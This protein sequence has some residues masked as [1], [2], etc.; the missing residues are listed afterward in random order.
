MPID[1][2]KLA[3]GTFIEYVGEF[4]NPTTDWPLTTSKLDN[5]FLQDFTNPDLFS[6]DVYGG[7]CPCG[8]LIQATRE[9]LR[10]RPQ[11]LDSNRP[12]STLELTVWVMV[13]VSGYGND[14]LEIN[15]SLWIPMETHLFNSFFLGGWGHRNLNRI[16]SHWH[17]FL[18][19][20][21]TRHGCEWRG[22]WA[23]RFLGQC[24]DGD[25]IDGDLLED[26]GSNWW[27]R[28]GSKPYAHIH[29]GVEATERG[30]ANWWVHQ[31]EFV[32]PTVSL[33]DVLCFGND[34]KILQSVNVSCSC[35]VCWTS[36]ALGMTKI[37]SDELCVDLKDNVGIFLQPSWICWRFL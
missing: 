27:T 16:H 35:K 9:W 34:S 17:Q 15:H 36:L 31:L 28:H 20:F 4:C 10:S 8:Q 37:P 26:Y 23:T 24:G 14:T 33:V 3:F 19:R 11:C 29:K 6:L 1:W 13:D 2:S 32:K 22:W 21:S 12:N 30:L 25:L 5:F 7:I 18:S